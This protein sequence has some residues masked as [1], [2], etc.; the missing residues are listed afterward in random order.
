[1]TLADCT[2]MV[3]EDHEFQRRTMVQI[4][5][6]LGAGSLLEAADGE[7]A[8]AVMDGAG[9]PD[10]VV[11][12]LDMPGM[13]GVEFFRHV[14]ERSI[15]TALVIASGLEERVLLSAAST[16]RAYGL[17]VL[18]VV[19]KPMTA[20]RI[21]EV[22]GLHR[23]AVT[24]HGP[25][26]NGAQSRAWQAALDQRAVT[27]AAR[28][29]IDLLTG[30]PAG[31]QVR[32]CRASG[33]GEGAV[34]AATDL[35]VSADPLL[36]GA[37]AGLVLDAACAAL[38]ALDAAGVHLDA[39]VVVPPAAC[40]DLALADGL[41]TR[42]RAA[43]VAPQRLCVALPCEPALPVGPTRMDVLTRLRLRG[44]GLG[45]EGF[46]AGD[47]MLGG[48]VGLPL[49]EVALAAD[50][51][52]AAEAG[53]AARARAEA[54]EGVVRGLH[55][56]GL[57]VVACGCEDA[58]GRAVAAQAGCDRVQGTGGEI[59]SALGELRAWAVAAPS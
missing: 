2:V 21:L 30:R 14:S 36:A 11:C 29:R 20:R 57:T 5:A 3:V 55:D 4:L 40:M 50:A 38:H 37:I 33:D 43:G 31:L 39:T 58:A 27:I 13:D 46:T 18:G 53:P 16:A 35:A 48:H 28:P 34:D 23:P 1:M 7:S 22:V 15:Q 52:G 47:A 12:D 41:A 56:Q 17:T 19:R 59:A 10:I 26:A 32:A 44:F 6:N 45:V 42:A 49:T 54:L 25:G 51:L 8:L 9:W 24:P